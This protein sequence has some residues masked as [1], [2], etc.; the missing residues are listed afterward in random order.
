MTGIER[1]AVERR[2]QIEV[3]GWTP[4]H[5]EQHE[6]GELAMA[7]A[8]YVLLDTK[9]IEDAPRAAIPS[10]IWPKEWS[11]AWRKPST[12]IRNLEKA[13][14]LIAAEIDRILR[15]ESEDET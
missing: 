2:R 11:L 9:A 5:D 7:A 3:E 1:I 6:R 4:E 15:L 14:A 12:R 10:W 13:G 8:Y